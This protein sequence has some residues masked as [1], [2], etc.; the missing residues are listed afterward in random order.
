M[1]SIRAQW[2]SVLSSPKKVKNYM[3]TVKVITMEWPANSADRSPMENLWEILKRKVADKQP[4]S[5]S[6]LVDVTKNVWINKISV[7]HSQN[8]ISSM[9]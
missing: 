5:T 4:S 1:H 2:F 9:L 8:L 3:T 6:T 7:E